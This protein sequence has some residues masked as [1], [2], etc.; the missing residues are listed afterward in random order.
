MVA[1][2]DNRPLWL[3]EAY[4]D[5]G[6]KELPG[7][8]QNNPVIV[9]MFK[10]TTYKATKDEVPWCSAAVN[11][12]MAKAGIM[13][14]KS[15]AAVSWLNWGQDLGDEPDLGCVVVFEWDSG[16]HHVSLYV[17]PGDGDTIQCLGGNQSN[18][19]KISTFPLRSVMSYRWPGKREGFNDSR[20]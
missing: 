2:T 18:M 15:A 6:Q 9:D 8:W 13:G 7:E 17:G 4:K 1:E 12:W 19:V 14:S 10:Y 16:D 11:K 3:I 5:L 20:G